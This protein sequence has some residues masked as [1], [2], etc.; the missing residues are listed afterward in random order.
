MLPPPRFELGTSRLL[1]ARSDQLSYGGKEYSEGIARFSPLG[2]EPRTLWC[3]LI[4]YSQ[5]LCQLSYGEAMI[6][7]H[8]E[9]TRWPL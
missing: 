8:P 7:Q 5:M 6:N 1:S 4:N 3:L 2:I 9:M